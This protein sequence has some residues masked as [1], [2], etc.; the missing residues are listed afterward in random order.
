MQIHELNNFTGTLGAGAYLAI[1][2]GTDTGKVSTQQILAN[3]EARI[4]NIIAGDAP[5]AAEVTDARYGADGVTYT[6]LGTAIRTQV[7]D[8][9]ADINQ[10]VV[11]DIPLVSGTYDSDGKTPADLSRRIRN[12]LTVVAETL[13][14]VAVPDAY[15]IWWFAL[16]SSMSKLAEATS[17][18]KSFYVAN[19]PVGTYYINFAIRKTSAPNSDIS[20]DIPTVHSGMVIVLAENQRITVL[21]S[22]SVSNN[23]A[24][25][26]IG[27]PY[28]E[29][30]K[31]TLQSDGGIYTNSGYGSNLKVS[32]MMSIY[33][34]TGKT[35]KNMMSWRAANAYSYAVYDRN[36]T[37]IGTAYG[38]VTTD[39]TTVSAVIDK[40][41]IDSY[42]NAC[43][44]RVAYDSNDGIVVVDSEPYPSYKVNAYPKIICCGDSVTAGFVVEGTQADPEQIYGVLDEYS[45]PAS[46][47]RI[48]AGADIT[49]VAQSGISVKGFYDTK[50]PTVD[51]SD[52]NLTIFEL[53]LNPG[54]E[55][56]LNISDWDV[57]GTSTYIYRQMI[58]GVRAQS[59]DIKIVLMRS[60]I[61]QNDAL[62][63]LEAIAS[64]S[65]CFVID[66]MDTKYINLNDTKY[67][68]Y[69]LNSG[70]ATL[71][72]THFNRIGY[73]AKAYDVAKWLGAL[74]P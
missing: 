6:S 10:M 42:P 27:T 31:S 8:L 73:T 62:A 61:Y 25:I 28:A 41:F 67:H 15:D 9:K 32:P 39:K 36:G 40:A 57:A 49:K 65:D 21:E 19:L 64:E 56:Y 5:S 16:D 29:V 12:K 60:Q 17:W 46:F 35:I 3:T 7:S 63:V 53:G 23:T 11:G 55:G 34:F 51:F 70:V 74:L 48:Y 50:Y 59:D 71:D 2:D 14:S 44:I 4:D 18:A 37:I 43:Y 68:G 58:A 66:L 38:A 1:D 47:N 20:S 24:K 54:N 72:P 52:Y 22:Q 69:Y 45:Y 26:F 33:E 13:Y 30:D